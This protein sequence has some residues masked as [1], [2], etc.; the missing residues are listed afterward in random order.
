MIRAG[1]PHLLAKSEVVDND[2]SPAPE[3]DSFDRVGI[4]E[5]HT[6]EVY[7]DTT[8]ECRLQ[9]HAKK[10]ADESPLLFYDLLVEREQILFYEF[11]DSMSELR[12]ATDDSIY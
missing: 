5:C 7:T 9:S 12:N 3:K 1:Y 10:I 6:M 8:V 4:D 11:D 2:L